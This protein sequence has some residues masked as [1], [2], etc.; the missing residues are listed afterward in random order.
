MRRKRTITFLTIFVSVLSIV[1]LLFVVVLVVLDASQHKKKVTIHP[2]TTQIAS[3]EEDSSVSEEMSEK[4]SASEIE[5]STEQASTIIEEQTEAVTQEEGSFDGYD[6]FGNGYTLKDGIK[7]FDKECPY[8]LCSAME[9]K[10]EEKDG[11]VTW[12][13]EGTDTKVTMIMATE[14][15]REK[16]RKVA[17]DAGFESYSLKLDGG[18]DEGPCVGVYN[19][20]IIFH[21]TVKGAATLPNEKVVH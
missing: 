3:T 10:M 5:I 14:I 16:Y 18:L 6:E 8:P 20:H 9:Q 12:Y 7:Y 11:V 13:Q 15:L 17:Q 2:S 4:E 21:A 19:G 1:T